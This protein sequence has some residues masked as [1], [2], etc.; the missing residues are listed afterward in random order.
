MRIFITLALFL[1]LAAA[2]GQ[3]DDNSVAVKL[4]ALDARVVPAAD[5]GSLPDLLSKQ[6]QSR[7]AAAHARMRQDWAMVQTRADWE[8]FRKDRIAALRKALGPFPKERADPKVRVTR[9]LEGEGFIVQNLVFESRPGLLV[10]ANLY[11]PAKPAGGK[12]PGIVIVHGFHQPKSQAELQDMGMTWARLGCAVLVP[13]VLGHGERRQ[14]PFKTEKDFA[15]K[16]ALRRQDYYGRANSAAQLELAGESLAGW[17]VWDTI[18]CVDVL[19]ARDDIDRNQ[20]LLLGAV[21][22]GGDVAAQ[23]A[24]LDER[25]TAVAPFNY[26][27]PEPETVHPLPANPDEAELAFPYGQGGHWDRTRR[28]QHAFRDGFFPW[29]VVA[30]A[31]PR[32]LVYSHEFA[33]DRERDPA[34]KRIEQVYQL[35]GVP[36][37][38]ASAHGS[39]TLF[40]NPEGTGC[41]NIGPVHR[42]E[43]YP[44]F[45]R[46]FGLPI[47]KKEYQK[48]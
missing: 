41:G 5:A 48:R 23:A 26:G 18:R 12:M 39:G 4:R 8:K 36:G 21:A 13:D 31:A 2:H 40:G 43:L 30:A 14:H 37:H 35:A 1:A 20:I 42:Q 33:W 10:T 38:L 24:A 28:L 6:Q 25:I 47:P 16:F 44:T 29:V 27:G 7:I 22:A 15:G 34:W 3:Q 32:R 17:M 11:L 46:W 19:L 45:Q 9:K